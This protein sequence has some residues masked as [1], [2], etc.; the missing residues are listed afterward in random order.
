MKRT[1]VALVVEDQPLIALEI[2]QILKDAG[3]RD[4][5]TF[6]SAGETENWLARQLPSVAVIEASVQDGHCETIARMLS[7]HAVPFIVHSVENE[8][9]RLSS[10]LRNC[11]AWIEKPG[12]PE[13][14]VAALGRRF[15]GF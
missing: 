4:I 11:K 14:F 12:T 13:M 7:D 3:W 6:V 1:N 5:L 9:R 15:D 10:P 2:E 8:G